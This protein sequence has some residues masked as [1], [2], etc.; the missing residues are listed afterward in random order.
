MEKTEVFMADP[1]GS[2]GGQGPDAAEIT[3]QGDPLNAAVKEFF[4][5]SYLFPYQRLVIAN[6]LEAAE[7]AGLFLKWPGEGAFKDPVPGEGEDSDRRCQGRQIVILP[8]GAG[9]SLC[10]QL[11]A[12]LLPGPTLVIYP[13]LSLMA[14]Q[15]RR[16]RERGFSPVILR[17]GQGPDERRLIWKK[18]RSGAGGFIIANPEVLLSPQV[19]AKLR[20]LR[21]LHIVIDEAHCVSEWGESFRPAYL[22]IG[23]I[24][25]AARFAPGP[26]EQG[27]VLPLIT[28]FTA[29]A[30]AAVMEKI[31][32]YIFG[33]GASGDGFS[34]AHR[35]SGNPDRA[36]ISYAARNCILRDL[37]VRDLII[38]NRRP[39]IVFCSTRSGTEKLARYLRNELEEAQIPGSREI[40]FYHAGLSREEKAETEN[41]F[42][43]NPQGVLTATNAFGMGV[44]KA[45]IRTVIHRD[46]PPS[47]EAYLQESGRAGRDSLPSAAILLW[48]P[49]DKGLLKRAKSGT[50]RRR[51]EALL[52]Y[53]GNT[54][55]CRR[56][57]L[58]TLLNYEGSGESPQGDCC[59]VCGGRAGKNPREEAALMDF[60][61]RNRRR[62]TLAE[63]VRELAQAEAPRWSGEDAQKTLTQL[64]EEGKLKGSKNPLWKSKLSPGPIPQDPSCRHS[65]RELLHRLQGRRISSPSS[66]EK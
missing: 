51:L 29:T 1:D 22:R 28:A 61:W 52:A 15:E 20:E 13:I 64:M 49:G 60:F 53:A 21:I 55:N 56:K 47:V 45:D 32:R 11:P 14:D 41:W 66:W 2:P 40:R 7:A 38:Q 27:G 63:A 54:Q 39:A 33:G 62:Y 59:D 30:S 23:E 31:E 57:A 12:M 19:L 4:G 43:R 5:L 44:D 46:C 8:T 18:I 50:E 10:F 34:G 25:E 3:G 58:L 42:L 36:N 26:D 9:K 16:L 37:A 24:I 35:I 17:G 65:L 6:I 48:G